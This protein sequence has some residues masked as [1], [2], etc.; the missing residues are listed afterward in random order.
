MSLRPQILQPVFVEIRSCHVTAWAICL[1]LAN[2][3]YDSFSLKHFIRGSHLTLAQAADAQMGF[4]RVFSLLTTPSVG[5]AASAAEQTV[6]VWVG[7]R[8]SQHLSKQRPGWDNESLAAARATG[9]STDEWF[10]LRPCLPP[11]LSL[12]HSFFLSPSLSLSLSIPHSFSLCKG[13]GEIFELSMAPQC[14]INTEM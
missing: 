2:V 4:L 8:R 11:S 1:S 14:L 9:P 3:T 13:E 5:G 12:V 7:R 6:C 10:S